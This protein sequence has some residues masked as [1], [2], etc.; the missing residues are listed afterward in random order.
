MTTDYKKTIQDLKLELIELAEDEGLDFAIMVKPGSG[1]MQ[2]TKVY[3]VNLETGEEVLLKD[4][5]I[6]GFSFDKLR[7]LRGA[8]EDLIAYSPNEALGMALYGGSGVSSFI[9]P[10]GM[11]IGSLQ[12]K[13]AYN[14][15][16]SGQEKVDFPVPP[17][18]GN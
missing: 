10:R 7:K 16:N 17:P 11:L 4:V 6:D 9:Y 15:F 2:A 13:P 3:K 14:Y 5:M 8:T 1:L 12:L 18:S